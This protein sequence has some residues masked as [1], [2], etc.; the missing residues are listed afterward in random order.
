MQ[1]AKSPAGRSDEYGSD[2]RRL[3]LATRHVVKEALSGLE[4]GGV[5]EFRLAGLFRRAGLFRPMDASAHR[6]GS[7]RQQDGEGDAVRHVGVFA[8]PDGSVVRWMAGAGSALILAADRRL[9]RYQVR[10]S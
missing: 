5:D 8:H 4:Q 10:W 1:G 9:P 6:G 7:G 2:A 3:W